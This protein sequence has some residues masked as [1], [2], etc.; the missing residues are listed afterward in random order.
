M[1]RRN[2]VNPVHAI[3]DRIE[4]EEPDISTE[5]LIQRVADE[6]TATTGHDWYADD[7]CAEIASHPGA[8]SK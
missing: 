2:R 5:Q 8:V 3:W 7:V 4:S 6:M 1:R